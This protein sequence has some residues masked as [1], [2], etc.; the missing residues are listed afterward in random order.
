METKITTRCW[1]VG[2]SGREF[3]TATGPGDRSLLSFIVFQQN[4]V[5]IHG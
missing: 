2:D 3:K 5:A 4:H 1:I